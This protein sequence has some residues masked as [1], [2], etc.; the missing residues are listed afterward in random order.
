MV[1]LIPRPCSAAGAV[2][3][4]IRD[5]VH[6]QELDL[7]YNNLTAPNLAEMLQM[8][9][10][11]GRTLTFY[12]VRNNPGLGGCEI[13]DGALK[14]FKALVCLSACEMDLRGKLVEVIHAL[15]T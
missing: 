11:L 3:A 15:K 2:P 6:L 4:Q 8:L 10:P 5:L 7:G 9:E 14:P 1:D 13:P 12:G